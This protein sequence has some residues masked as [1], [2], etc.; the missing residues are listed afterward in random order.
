VGDSGRVVNVLCV[1]LGGQ[2][3]LLAS[4]ILARAAL[5]AGL[6]VKKSEVH[7]MSQRGGGVTSHVRFGPAVFSPL[8]PMGQSDYILALSSEEGEKYRPY[9]K[10]GGAFLMLPG[11]V[12]GR[13]S[14]P[15]MANVAACGLL[16]R[17]LSLPEDAWE[18][19]VRESVPPGTE[20]ANWDAFLAGE[21]VGVEDKR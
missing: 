16:S 14:S 10:E 3:V 18:K 11:K 7:G 15:R 21:A 17:S 1:G 9:L 4:E 2:G 6:E 20:G 13:L 12:V 19:A 5:L 8:I